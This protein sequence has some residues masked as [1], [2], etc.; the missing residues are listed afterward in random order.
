MEEIQTKPKK[1]TQM[2]W[3]FNVIQYADTLIKKAFKKKFHKK[4]E[5][6]RKKLNKIK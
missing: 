4:Y 6:S 2:Q 3:F 5:K 1:K